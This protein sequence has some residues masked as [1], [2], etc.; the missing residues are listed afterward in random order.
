T[1]AENGL[2]EAFYALSTPAGYGPMQQIFAWGGP[3]NYSNRGFLMADV[4]GDGRADLVV[5]RAEQGR[6]Q[7][8][9]PLSTPTGYAPFQQIFAWGGPYDCS[10]RGFL[11]ADVNGDGRA[12]W[13]VTRAEQG[14][15]QASYTLSTPTGY[16]PLQQVFEW[17]GPYDY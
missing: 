10:N 11:M 1:R 7:A 13:V 3:Y 12:D 16:A 17:G 15:A 4:N 2:A 9:Y 14:R 8:S 5:T 6:A